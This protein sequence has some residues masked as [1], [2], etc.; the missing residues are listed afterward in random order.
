MTRFTKFSG[1]SLLL[2]L[3]ACGGS[4]PGQAD[5]GTGGVEDA[6]IGD[7]AV[8]DSGAV[9]SG[10]QP[11]GG[12]ESCLGANNGVT[13]AFQE[14]AN[15]SDCVIV[16]Y[17][18][19]CCGNGRIVGVHTRHESEAKACIDALAASLPKCGCPAMP[20]TT[21]DGAHA[22]SSGATPVVRCVVVGGGSHADIKACRTSY[23]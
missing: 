2:G 8:R 9:D 21:D 18:T 19:D 20:A 7:G 16:T 12:G 1:G 6:S 23:P 22:T 13:R 15:D 14:C 4:T 3:V 5:G 11:D 10:V 17:P